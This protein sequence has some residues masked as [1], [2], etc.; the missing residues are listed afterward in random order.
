MIITVINLYSIIEHPEVISITHTHTLNTFT[1]KLIVFDVG[2][3][4]Q[5]QQH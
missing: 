1:S 3:V 5:T 2:E 4:L